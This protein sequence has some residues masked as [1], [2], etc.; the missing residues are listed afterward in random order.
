[1]QEVLRFQMSMYKRSMVEFGTW[2]LRNPE[3]KFEVFKHSMMCLPLICHSVVFDYFV[4][5]FIQIRIWLLQEVSYQFISQTNIK[6][7]LKTI[8]NQCSATQQELHFCAELLWSVGKGWHKLSQLRLP[9]KD[10]GGLEDVKG[11]GC[12]RQLSDPKESKPVMA[13]I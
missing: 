1:M 2:Q 7:N 6:C 3:S 5:A 9:R 13:S 11:M 12:R 8:F 10:L 4:H